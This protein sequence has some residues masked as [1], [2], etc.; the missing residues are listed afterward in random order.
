[1]P[2]MEIEIEYIEGKT[3]D[4]ILLYRLILRLTEEEGKIM[5]SKVFELFRMLAYFKY[6]NSNILGN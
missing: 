2:K 3:D 5:F 1:M 6:T 4:F